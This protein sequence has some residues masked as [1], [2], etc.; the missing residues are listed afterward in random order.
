MNFPDRQRKAPAL[1]TEPTH[2][3]NQ[4]PWRGTRQ[5][6]NRRPMS[7][8]TGSV[9]PSAGGSI[10]VSGVERIPSALRSWAD[11]NVVP[12]TERAVDDYGGHSL[13]GEGAG[14]GRRG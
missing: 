10:L 3:A 11:Y 12:R 9:Y 8:L 6:K 5:N 2:V 13:A 7:Q 14:Q 4:I 1:C